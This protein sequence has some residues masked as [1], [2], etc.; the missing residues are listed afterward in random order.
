M[1]LQSAGKSAIQAPRTQNLIPTFIAFLAM[2]VVALLFPPAAAASATNIYLAQNS[3]GAASGTACADAFPASFFNSSSNWGS[4]ANQIGPGTT[5]H[6]CGTI[7]SDLTFQGN[8]AS[9]NPVVL[10][11]TGATLSAHLIIGAR[12]YWTVQHVTWSTSFPTDGSIPL[13]IQGGS[14]GTVNGNT[15]DVYSPA[16]TIFLQQ[17]SGGSALAH[18]IVISNNFLRTSATNTGAQ[19]D[20][21]DTEGS[22]NITVEGNYFEM[23][24]Q[25]NDQHDDCLQTWQKGGA[26]AGPPHDWTIRYNEFVMN[27]TATN[28]KSWHMIEGMGPGAV[29]IYGN[30]YVGTQGA[31]QANGIT[32]DSNL[33]GMIVNIYGN[34]IVE[35]AGGPN[36]LFNITGPG[37]FNLSDNIIY[38]TDA[39]NAL[40]GGDSLIRTHNLW[41]GA[42]IPS[43]VATEI[44]GQNP[45][46]N[47]FAGG[48][49]S[50]QS[51]SPAMGVGVNLGT[52][53][54]QY[55][56]PETAWPN[57][58]LGTRS[59]SGLWDLG[60]FS[61][62]VTASQPSPPSSLTALVN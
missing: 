32:L 53:Y 39:G 60:A 33:T 25:N 2:A 43:C 31:S 57:P 26:S 50:L 35:K 19:T 3:A 18:D 36:N 16:P 29:N 34:T 9:G 20:L 13:D 15:L 22:Y 42:N 28:N 1:R 10:D 27:T 24:S 45:M 62:G 4:G 30:L 12:S 47:N 14:F 17:T 59:A 23:R 37:I 8:G 61:A 5:V 6:L 49:Y 58:Q 48:D 55:P 51:S 46:F 21:L 40:T 38:N 56:L 7:T 11:G 52:A 44:C 41:Y 54:N